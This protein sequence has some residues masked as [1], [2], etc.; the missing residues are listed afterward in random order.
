MINVGDSISAKNANWTFDGKVAENFEPHVK[1]SVPFYDAGHGLILET[2]DYFVKDD[3]T[4]YELG[5][6]TG[7]LSYKLS[8]RFEEKKATFIGLDEIS[9]MIKYAENKYKNKNLKFECENVVDYEY[10]SSDLITSYYLLQFIRP[11][12]RQSLIDKVYS[13]L[14]WGGAFI[15]F[16]KVRGPDARFQDISNGLYQEY[17]INNGYS[18]EEIVS[19]SRSLKGILEPFSTNGNIEMFNRA[20]FKDISSIFKY[21]CFE[22]FL[23]IK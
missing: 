6:S 7:L 13:T 11:S 15:C 20:G 16:E 21:I 18:Y 14:N 2:A 17:K 5:C 9:N 10:L 1:K 23:C 8:K 19:K 3:S 12:Q 22:G 4:V